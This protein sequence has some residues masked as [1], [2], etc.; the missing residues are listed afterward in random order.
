M[1]I[2]IFGAGVY[3]KI[4]LKYFEQIGQNELIGFL[5]N[6]PKAPVRTSSGE[7]LPVYR[8][9]EAVNLSHDLIWISNGQS[10]QVAEI[11]EQLSGLGFS[12]EKVKAML[13]E[14]ETMVK[15]LTSFNQYDEETDHRVLWLRDYAAYTA[16]ENFPGDV[17][18][19][20][21]CMGDFSYY[22][23]KYFPDKT[24]YL[25]DTF[26]GFT[27]QDLDVERA[28]NNGAFMNSMFND[29][30]FFSSANEQVVITRMLHPENC[31]L[32]KGY[33]PDT[34]EGIE[35]PFCFVN[36]D[37]DLYQPMLA[38][39]RFF[40]ERM[41]PGGVL[42]LHDYFNPE[43]PGVRQAVENFERERRLKIHKVPVGD[44]CSIAIVVP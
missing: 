30:S 17:A 7:E 31:V 24:L 16:S 27:L 26:E 6:A 38:G 14:P 35:G 25:F 36:L 34:A 41:C 21:V 28:F 20:G 37:M 23:N 13:E 22:I 40:Y 4:C 33:F 8:P 44:S 5:D 42:L 43:L 11:K 3:G 29:P 39:L 1:K 2:L 18:E 9:E 10:V 12:P 19:C 15:I 32:K